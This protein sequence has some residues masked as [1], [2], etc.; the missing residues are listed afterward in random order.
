M[1]RY[2]IRLKTLL[3]WC[4]AACSAALMTACVDEIPGYG[5][6]DIPEGEVTVDLQAAFSPF[7][8]SILSRSTTIPGKAMADIS[9]LC[10]LAYGTDG[11]LIDNEY[12]PGGVMQ[13][14]FA[15]SDVKDEPRDDHDASNGD[16]AEASTKCLQKTL[17]LPTGRYYLIAVANLGQYTR[18]EDGSVSVVS[19]TYDALKA[20]GRYA[21]MYD[22]LDELRAMTV[23]WD[24]ENDANNREML[25]FFT[26]SKDNVPSHTSSFTPVTVNR[27]GLKFHTWLRRCASKVTIDF[28]GSELRENVRVYL[29]EARIYDIPK[30]CTLGFGLKSDSDGGN[31]NNAAGKDGIFTAS[32]PRLT[33]AIIYGEGDDHKA[34]PAITKGTP[35]GAYIEDGTKSADYD[36]S[37]LHSETADALF[38]Y[39]NMQ[40]DAPRD[41]FQ[42]ADLDNGGVQDADEIKDGIPYGT[43]I[44]VVGHYYSTANGAVSEGDIRYRFMLGKDVKRNCDAERN[45]HYKLTL[46][47]RGNANDYD[48]HINYKEADGFDIPNPWY[49]SYLYNHDAIMPFKYTPPQGWK[50]TKIEAKIVENPWYPTEVPSDEKDAPFNQV[51]NRALGNG[52][53][54]LHA[55]EKTVI[56]WDEAGG[57]VT[58]SSGLFDYTAAANEKANDKY[59]Y[60]EVSDGDLDRSSRTYYFDGTDDVTNNGRGAYSYQK[61]GDKYTFNI[62]LFTRAKVLIKETGY[63]GN[64]PYVGYERHAKLKLIA[65]LE[66][67]SGQTKSDEDETTVIQVRRI[68]NP[69]GVYR[70]SGNNEDFNVTLLRLPGDD[71][72]NFVEFKSDGPWLAEIV[73]DKN[74]ITLDGKQIV[75]GST[76]T[77]IKF[78]I[79]FNKFNNDKKIRNAVVRV[80][81][82]NYTCYHLIFVRQGYDAQAISPTGKNLD[83]DNVTATKW[84]TFNNIT[85]S[86]P[87]TDPRDEGS[88]FKFGNPWWPI[89]AYCN[90]YTDANGNVDCGFP[91]DTEFS[92]PPPV[93]FAN[94]DGSW[95]KH[96][97]NAWNIGSNS[98]GFG[99]K[100]PIATARDFEQLYLTPHI[101]FGYGVL[102]ADGATET[103]MSVNDAYGWYRRDID[104]EVPDNRKGMRGMFAYYWNVNDPNNAY[105]AKNVFFP[106]GRSGYGHR[107][108][109]RSTASNNEKAGTLRY[110][111]GRSSYANVFEKTAPLF[112]SLYR[113]PGAIYW[114]RNAERIYKSW[115]DSTTDVDKDIPNP[116]NRPGA[117]MFGL[118]INYFTFDVN[119]IQGSNMDNGADACFIRCVE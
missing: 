109:T 6:N 3:S 32:E 40:G 70:K 62:P 75:T 7:T 2:N 64:N 84:S 12:F 103:Q 66:N 100:Y 80:K 87:A 106:I 24:L 92:T 90:V 52:F 25:G 55:T 72:A 83:G 26:G 11:R 104:G 4:V 61:D 5:L 99:D 78:T 76:Q 101:Q 69:K 112:C 19:S 110:A 79:K 44:E 115:D 1:S 107:K 37:R 8:E 29:K 35:Y 34:W 54:S 53:L 21:G 94:D 43:Y 68:V 57:V 108:N 28:D 98:N 59:F 82:H 10:L 33:N 18:N 46:R 27:A 65:H 20:G 17:T 71:A 77:P 117:R 91:K 118:D 95:Y 89:D 63:S 96:E 50:V 38:F 105:T 67:E 49:I 47:L 73:G 60:G 85:M 9:D 56:T 58:N 111:C 81:Y 97:T 114:A 30:E 113:R 119:A 31:Y 36:Y 15:P 13:I 86:A 74:F 102:Y 116:D 48:W 88:M 51:S 45:Y 16:K 93:Y 14:D 42:I 22:T 39:E 23:G 41:K